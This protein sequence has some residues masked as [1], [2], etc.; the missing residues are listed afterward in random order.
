MNVQLQRVWITLFFFLALIAVAAVFFFNRE[1]VSNV[2]VSARENEN[3]ISLTRSVDSFTALKEVEIEESSMD[4]YLPVVSTPAMSQLSFTEQVNVKEPVTES[5]KA[6]EV[7]FGIDVNGNKRKYLTSSVVRK[8]DWFAKIVGRHWEDLFLWPDLYMLNAGQMRTKD[9]DLIYPDET[10]EIYQSLVAD[11][12]FSEDDRD[13]LLRSYLK[14][15]GMYKSLGSYKD[16][17]AGRLLAS[18]VRYDKDFLNRYSDQI[19]AEDR[20]LAEQLLAEQDYLD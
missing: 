16:Q 1:G 2:V 12:E 7:K 10:V 6:E 3:D 15:Y 19:E 13:V 14:V 9:P 17:A 4:S 5:K 8:G 20:K 11:G 18:A